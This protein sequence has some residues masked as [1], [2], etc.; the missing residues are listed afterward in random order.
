[1]RP[2]TRLEMR[3]R[4]RK[5]RYLAEAAGVGQSQPGGRIKKEGAPDN[6]PFPHRHGGLVLIPNGVI[7]TVPRPRRRWITARW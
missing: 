2:A 6:A 1:M 5:V 4:R 7:A 3:V